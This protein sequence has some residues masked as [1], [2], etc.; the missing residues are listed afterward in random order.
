MKKVTVFKD[1]E[2]FSELLG[3]NH[4]AGVASSH[5][6]LTRSGNVTDL[7][8]F[9]TALKEVNAGLKGN[10]GQLLETAYSTICGESDHKFDNIPYDRGSDVNAGPRH[11][12]IK[13]SGFTLMSGS[14][15]EGRQSFDAI[16]ELYA[17]KVVSNEWTYITKSGEAFEMNF[18]E[19]KSFVYEFCTTEKESEK[20][21]GAMKIRC[22][23]E[24]KKMLKWL[25]ARV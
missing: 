15:C 12:S 11:I 23:K 9:V 5:A 8:E 10:A 7:S 1:F 18:D 17:S 20:N 13:S 2:Q 4:N 25:D 3:L 19:F 24:S 21:G 14:L 16:W 6:R 22:R